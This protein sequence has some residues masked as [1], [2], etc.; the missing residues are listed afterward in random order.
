[1]K[2][3]SHKPLKKLASKNSDNKTKYVNSLNFKKINKL[4]KEDD[5]KLLWLPVC[6]NKGFM[7][8]Y[9]EKTGECQYSYPKIYDDNTQSYLS[10]LYDIK[11]IYFIKCIKTYN[12]NLNLVLKIGLK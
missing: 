5:S 11:S 12:I 9:N 1:M 4:N 8:F 3:N 2:P 6:N 10:I 7:Y